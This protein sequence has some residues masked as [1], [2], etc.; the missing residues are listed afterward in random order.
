M[1]QPSSPVDAT[2]PNS[3]PS[4]QRFHR[5]NRRDWISVAASATA[6]QAIT[7][8]CP[9]AN[10][11]GQ[12]SPSTSSLPTPLLDTPLTTSV[13]FRDKG[14]PKTVQGELV[15][16]RDGFGLLILD[17]DGLLTAIAPDELIAKEP[18]TAPLEPT[19]PVDLG[20]KMLRW[21][22]P[23]SRV[24]ASEHFL[25]CYN[26]T[27]AYA[28]WNVDLYER[29]Y[30]GFHRFW[31][32]KGFELTPP[33]FPL[34]SLIFE[35][36]ADYVRYAS[37]EFQGS[38][39]TFGYYHQGT[40]RLASYDLTGVEG[41]IPSNMRV[42][43]DTLVQQILS[44][45]EAERTVATIVHE[46]CHQ[47]AFNCGLQARLGA[48]PLWLSEGLAT[49]FESPDLTS[50][51][52]WGGIGKINQHNYSNLV[53]YLPVRTTES[54]TLLLSD[55]NRLRNGETM[56]QSYAEAWGL[57]H[58]LVQTRSRDFVKYLQRVREIP[59]GTQPSTRERLD[60]FRSCFGDDLTKIDRDFLRHLQRLR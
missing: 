52:G 37:Q 4:P 12:D 58:F 21:M 5:A 3:T 8:L 57:T 11:L 51:G 29:L 7:S 59:I 16:E 19:K 15:A 23:N 47:I 34:V 14:E 30:R 32:S 48:S 55:D 56:T 54:L 1:N 17:A 53:Q 22:P 9:D 50:K 46:A 60:M 27:E 6:L 20:Q 45:P 42:N 40:N 49:Y 13:Q 24:L 44:R 41:M 36:K 39:N 31:K 43:R 26:T 2:K 18:L 28:R 35:T 10:L 38:E 33:R 25:L